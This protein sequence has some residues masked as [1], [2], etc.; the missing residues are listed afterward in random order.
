[1]TTR[2]LSPMRWKWLLIALLAA[3]LSQ[4]LPQ[5]QQDDVV[6]RAM[7]DEMARSMGQLQLQQMDKPYF[8]AYRTQ[9]IT[10]HEISATLG[11]LTS[12][13][14]TPFRN[15][16]V[17]VELRV[18]DYTLDNTN[19][20]S[21]QRLRG[22][23]AGMFGGI[24]QGSLDNDYTQIRRE[25]WLATDKEYKRALE[26]L[27]AKKAALKMRNGGESLPDFSKEAPLT[28]T[29]PL[30]LVFFNSGNLESLARELSAVF[31]SAPEIDLSS[32]IIN[33]RTVSTHYVNSEGTVYTRYEPLIK[34]EV[35]ARTH[36]ADGVPIANSFSV[37]GR[38]IADLPPKEALL[39]RTQ[40]MSALILQLR[41]ASSLDRYNGPVLF[42]GAAAGE[43]FMQQFGSRLAASRTP[44]SD[45]PQFEM[46]FNQMLD[47]LGGASFQDKLG[48][49][50][51]PDFISVRDD[52]SQAGF[53]G[54]TLM[55]SSSVDDDGIKTRE[56]VLID[57]GILKGLLTSRVP[58]RGFLH[59]SGS[60]HG[61]GAVPSNLFVKSDK[62]MSAEDLRK[63]LLRRAKDR[64]LDYAIV[65]RHVGGGSAASFMQMA[66]QMANQAGS[67]ESLLE[68][69][70]LYPD[71]HEEPLRGVHIAELPPES[72]KEI[73][74]T[75]DTPVLFNDEIIPRMTSLFSMGISSG[76]DLPVVSCVSPS[77]LFEELSL[78]KSEGPYPAPPIS[79]SPLAEK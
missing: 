61:W 70:K 43:V 12:S 39:Q 46:F 32:V 72:F 41:S 68:V 17:G 25:F 56:T 15:R 52:P 55:G 75:G 16:L 53:N 23:L 66:R 74:A 10:Q 49:R 6:T 71:G 22:G 1:M 14:G 64:G 30:T 77:L 48:A 2:N 38:T 36:A 27:S 59:S 24:E 33:Y 60:R 78:A 18:G 19:F 62:T 67:S 7:K 26:D 44:I 37:Y 73:I 57:H 13:S 65:V 76:G 20:F 47:R 31:R 21:M 63:E 5:A 58:V 69:F 50:I 29:A 79:L 11:S 4:A 28:L 51:L 40:Q 34:L 54:S 8:L 9:D 45:N 42:E 35:S 3:P